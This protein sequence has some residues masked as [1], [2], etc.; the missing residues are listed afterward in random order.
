MLSAEQVTVWYGPPRRRVTAVAGASLALA[1][2]Q[3]LGLVGPSG[4]GKSSLAQVLALLRAPDAGRVRLDGQV[5]AGAGLAVPRE[6]RRHVQLI[7]QSPRAAVD[8]R[9]RLDRVVAEPLAAHGHPPATRQERVA[10]VAEMVGLTG[11]LLTRYPHEVSDGQLQRAA[12]ARAL[13][14]APRYLVCDEPTAMLDVST[15]AS[16]LAVL[17]DFQRSDGAGILLITHDRV[18][19]DHWCDRVVD[20]RELSGVSVAPAAAA[21]TPPGSGSAA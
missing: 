17:A 16:L 20:I 18:L 3:R 7:W 2:G 8:P 4:S 21:P 13:V 11:E 1:P 19:A 15:Q 12:L 14:L 9:L 5:V 6:V 10:Q